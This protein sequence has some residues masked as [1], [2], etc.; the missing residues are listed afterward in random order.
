[1]IVFT[2]ESKS[3]CFSDVY[4]CLKYLNHV[5]EGKGESDD[6]DLCDG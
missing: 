6:I 1:M 3:L 5:I 4:I 2:C